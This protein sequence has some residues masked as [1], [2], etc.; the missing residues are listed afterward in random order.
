MKMQI[1]LL[2]NYLMVRR[3]KNIS[4]AEKFLVHFRNLSL[5]FCRE[6]FPLISREQISRRGGGVGWGLLFGLWDVATLH[7]DRK[8]SGSISSLLCGEV[9]GGGRV[10]KL[11]LLE[12]ARSVTSDKRRLPFSRGKKN[13]FT[14]Q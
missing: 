1:I 10:V 3:K 8:F 2:F 6:S 14:S 9:G 4:E 5:A 11:N 12:T 13:A 7:F